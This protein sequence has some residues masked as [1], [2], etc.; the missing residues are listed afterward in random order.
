MEGGKEAP[1]SVLGAACGGLRPAGAGGTLQ[2]LLSCQAPG[3]QAL[4]SEKE[5]KHMKETPITFIKTTKANRGRRGSLVEPVLSD[6]KQHSGRSCGALRPAS[7]I[8]L[9]GPSSWHIPRT[10][11]SEQ[12]TAAQTPTSRSLIPTCWPDP[13]AASSRGTCRRG[14]GQG[15]AACFNS[16]NCCFPMGLRISA[17]EGT[18]WPWLL[19]LSGSSRVEFLPGRDVGATCE[20]GRWSQGPGAGAQRGCAMRWF[21]GAFKYSD[22]QA[23]LMT[24]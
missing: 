14:P 11:F 1:A 5:R 21:K 23:Q 7:R 2:R 16:S 12:R 10:R 13:E 17:A 6:H 22:F 19:I 8:L 9:G 20:R 15:A 24:N 18:Q 3:P 4:K